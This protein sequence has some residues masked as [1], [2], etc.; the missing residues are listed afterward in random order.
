M[1]ANW[2][3]PVPLIIKLPS[4]AVSPI[5][6]KVVV[7]MPEFKVKFCTAA[8]VPLIGLLKVMLP[9]PAVPNV[10]RVVVG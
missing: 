8:V 5:P 4:G 10:V 2:V 1:P 9:L 3:F 6:L 7:P